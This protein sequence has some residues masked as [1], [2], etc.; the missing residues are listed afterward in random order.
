MG[1]LK[2]AIRAFWRTMRNDVTVTQRDRE[3]LEWLG[4]NGDYEETSEATY[5]TCLRLLSEAIGKMP[6]KYYQDTPDRGR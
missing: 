3:L 4:I 6:I 5:F 1:K 2:N